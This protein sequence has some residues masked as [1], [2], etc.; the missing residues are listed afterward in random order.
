MTLTK[1]DFFDPTPQD[2]L[3]LVE[4]IATQKRWDN[5]R[6]SET[7]MVIE[8]RGAWSTYHMYFVWQESLS[9]LQFCCQFDFRVPNPTRSQ[10]HTLL[11][12]INERL[13][14]G[15]FDLS[16]DEQTPMFRHNLLMRTGETAN[17]Q[18]IEDVMA[19]AAAEC[20]RFYPAFQFVLWGNRSPQDAIGAALIHTNGRA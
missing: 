10:V 11:S 5:E 20:D 2:P 6:L 4:L 13:W 19:I 9:A 16:T 3:S 12:M 8:V 15:H 18:Q 14:L 17:A 1:K 7:E